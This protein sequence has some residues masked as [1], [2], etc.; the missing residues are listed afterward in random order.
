MHRPILGAASVAALLACLPAAADPAEVAVVADPRA[1]RMTWSSDHPVSI[2]TRTGA[3][4]QGYFEPGLG[5]H[6]RF[7]PWASVGIEGFS[8][9]YA[10][11]RSGD[12]KRDLVNGFNLFFPLT[13]NRS[14]TVAPQFGVCDEFQIVSPSGH[15]ASGP[16]VTDV[17]LGGHAG[18]QVE[19]RLGGGLAVEASVDGYAYV[20]HSAAVDQWTASLSDSLSGHL[21]AVS[22]VGFNY[23][24]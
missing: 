2:G 15:G 12:F 6:I 10:R 13:R 20:G 16:S 7:Q 5:G 23:Y 17:L 9:N 22:T 24:F 1:D 19:A 21:V 4:D 18:V 3:W 8:D 11:V 14:W